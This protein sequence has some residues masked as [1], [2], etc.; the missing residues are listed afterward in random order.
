MQH[1]HR[2]VPTKSAVT[3]DVERAH[4]AAAELVA[5]HVRALELHP[6][7]RVDR[8]RDLRLGVDQRRSVVRAGATARAKVCVARRASLGSG[9]VRVERDLHRATLSRATSW[10]H[11][12][13]GPTPVADETIGAG[14]DFR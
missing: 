3:G 7:Q 11:E 5:E 2:D 6:D 10:G 14:D 12:T 1:L 13:G 4:A 9:T 8:T